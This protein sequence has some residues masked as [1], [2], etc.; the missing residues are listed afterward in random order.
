[1]KI[2]VI[3]AG[4]AGLAAA[5]HLSRDHKVVIF[6]AKGIGGG[7][8]G[9]STGLL[10]PYPGEQ[11]RRSWK[12]IEAM[13]TARKLLQEAEKALG[14]P[15]ASYT[16]ILKIGECVGA[17][18]DVEQL[19][20]EQFLIHSGITVFTKLYLEGLF[21]AGGAEL[22]LQE[23]QTL[24]ELEG[25][26]AIILAVGAGIC[27]FSEC[28][29]LRLNFVKGQILTCEQKEPLERSV[30][31][32]RYTA[33]TQDPHVCHIGATYERDFVSEEPCLETAQRLLKPESAVLD[34]KAGV[35]VTNPAHYFPMVEKINSKTWAITAL[36]SRG[37]LYHGYLGELI[38]KNF[39][40]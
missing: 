23:I 19:G 1:M 32:K 10:H 17:G 34:C 29:H 30:T 20:L 35:R 26:D 7:A 31:G 15:V 38:L 14:R 2:A 37:L 3:G 16:G 9:V 22:R 25:F 39:T 24:E 27:K 13:I 6:D 21:Q 18:D 8:S 4:F 12:A 28:K 40:L 33:I 11:G 5:F 36:G